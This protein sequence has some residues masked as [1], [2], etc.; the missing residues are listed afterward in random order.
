MEYGV[1]GDVRALREE[2]SL[3]EQRVGLCTIS[4]INQFHLV[5]HMSVL[6]CV[7]AH[8]FHGET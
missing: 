4:Q 2:E 5:I 6:R 8:G 1:A 3:L 7:T